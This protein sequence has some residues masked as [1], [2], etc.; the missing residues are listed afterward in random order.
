MNNFITKYND[1][2]IFLNDN[3]YSKNIFILPNNIYKHT[4]SDID[5]L[6]FLDFSKIINDYSYCDES[7][8]LIGYKKISDINETLKDKLY[9]HDINFD[10]MQNKA[11]YRTYNILLSEDRSVYAILF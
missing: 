8:I 3:V 2:N 11:A 4:I 7:I 6:T 9:Q 5:H 1:K 10:I